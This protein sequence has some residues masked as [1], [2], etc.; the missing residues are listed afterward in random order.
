MVA[1]QH[2]WKCVSAR[3][4]HLSGKSSDVIKAQLAAN[5][6][7]RDHDAI[8]M[9]RRTMVQ[10]VMGKID[11]GNTLLQTHRVHAFIE[12]ITVAH[13]HTHKRCRPRSLALTSLTVSRQYLKVH[14][15]CR[16]SSPPALELPVPQKPLVRNLLQLQRAHVLGVLRC[17]SWYQA[18]PFQWALVLHRDPRPPQLDI[19]IRRLRPLDPKSA[20]PTKC[21]PDMVE[22]R[23]VQHGR[24]TA[25]AA[26]NSLTWT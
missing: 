2:G 14:N 4:C 19:M 26:A 6:S 3:A 24:A 9:F 1:T 13:T 12:C 18:L 16:P 21:N 15:R 25:T 22:M 17:K 7:K 10:T 11:G 20:D 8:D 23:L 5:A